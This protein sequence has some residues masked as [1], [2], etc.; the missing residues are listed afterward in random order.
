MKITLKTIRESI[1]PLGL[2]LQAS[3]L[4]I[5]KAYWLKKLGETFDAEAKR[6]EE[7]RVALVE[8]HFPEIETNPE[9][10]LPTER[11]QAF[12]AAFADFLTTEIDAPNLSLT[13]DELERIS[14]LSNGQIIA[15]PL[16]ARDLD[17]LS[18]LVEAPAEEPA[19]KAAGA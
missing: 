15:N 4:N 16:S 3:G 11:I 1:G 2:L 19:A 7:H 13:L 6:I 12:E 8:E 14:L 17:L 9:A 18:W 10:T 5:K